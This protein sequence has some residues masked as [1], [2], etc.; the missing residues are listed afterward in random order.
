[1]LDVRAHGASVDGVRPFRRRTAR[2]RALSDDLFEQLIGID[3]LRGYSSS[4]VAKRST[5]QLR[6]RDPARAQLP[7]EAFILWTE[8]HIDE[9]SAHI[10]IVKTIR[11]YVNRH[12]PKIRRQAIQTR[13]RLAAL[14]CATL[15]SPLSARQR[16]PAMKT[17]ASSAAP[18]DRP[19]VIVDFSVTEGRLTIHLKNVGARSAYL[20]KTVFDKPFSG[21]SGSKEISA[22]RVFR[23]VDFMAPGKEFSQFVDLLSVYAK[24]KQPMRLEATVS[25]ADREGNR[26]RDRIVHDLR[27]YL[28]LGQAGVAR[29]AP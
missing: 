5:D 13:F 2:R 23:R 18:V 8:T 16:R 12:S 21:L 3:R 24:R 19:E 22:M 6:N 25:Y 15:E 20:V 26:F 9:S 29:R 27:T 14:G 7:G 17:N 28:E 1:L 4:L 10:N 11:L